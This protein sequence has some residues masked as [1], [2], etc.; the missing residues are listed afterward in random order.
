[1]RYIY[2]C[3]ECGYLGTMEEKNVEMDCP[4]C[5]KMLLATHIE[6]E[7]WLKMNSQE[8]T[9]HK[10]KWRKQEEE[11]R[12]RERLK[13]ETEKERVNN[14]IE[15]SG[16]FWEYKVVNLEDNYSGSV[17]LPKLEDIMNSL[18]MSGWRLRCAYTNEIGRTSSSSG[19]Y[20][21]TTGTNATI[22]QNILIF[23]RFVKAN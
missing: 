8:K 15:H 17:D 4:E 1:M 19:A 10:E 14:A 18:G 6:K 9:A 20:G 12:Q 23:E 7:D 5:G 11:E 2:Y 13:I 3:T 16:G 21:Y 22:D